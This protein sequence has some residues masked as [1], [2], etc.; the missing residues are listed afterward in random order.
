M[1]VAVPST[2]LHRRLR[3]LYELAGQSDYVF[4]SPLGP[5]RY[6][7]RE[8]TVP[9]FV[10]FGPQTSQDSLRLAVL[11]GFGRHDRLAVQSLL[12][13]VGGLARHPE[14]GAS[15]NVSFFPLVNVAGLLGGVEERDLTAAHWGRSREPEIVLLNQDIRRC[16]YQAFIRLTTTADDTPAAWVRFVRPLHVHPT[17]LEVFE[18]TDFG[19]WSVRFETLAPE[20]V[21]LGPLALADDLAFAPFEVELALPADWPQDTADREVAQLLK[22]LIT[23]YRGFLAYGQNL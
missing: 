11:A 16:G 3:A 10:Y 2:T 4:G 1:S 18:S 23:R 7:G 13:F 21:P 6:E 14:I 20:S 19:G 12:T 17:D 9:R 8:H 5:F 22:R 15:L